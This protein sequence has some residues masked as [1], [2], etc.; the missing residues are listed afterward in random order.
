VTLGFKTKGLLVSDWPYLVRIF[1]VTF[2]GDKGKIC[3]YEILYICH[4]LDVKAVVYPY[5]HHVCDDKE[6]G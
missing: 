5:H 2:N 6:F 4:G 1:Q 3:V